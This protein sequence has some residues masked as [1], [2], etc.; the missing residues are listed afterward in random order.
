MDCRLKMNLT[1]A[2]EAAVA[3]G[4]KQPLGGLRM[5]KARRIG[6]TLRSSQ[7][8]SRCC[9]RGCDRRRRM[10]DSGKAG[11]KCNINEI[12]TLIQGLRNWRDS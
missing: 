5:K 7:A 8:S 2:K 6:K 3:V 1:E 10:K 12:K 9:R 4:Q 11:H